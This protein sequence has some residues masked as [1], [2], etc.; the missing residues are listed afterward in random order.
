MGTLFPELDLADRPRSRGTRA[1]CASSLLDVAADRDSFSLRWRERLAKLYEPSDV[2]FASCNDSTPLYIAL[3]CQLV[4]PPLPLLSS[5]LC[6]STYRADNAILSSLRYYT[7]RF[8][9]QL[10]IQ[11]HISN[12][13]RFLVFIRLVCL[14]HCRITRITSR[15]S[16]SPLLEAHPLPRASEVA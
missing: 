11:Y 12:P 10:E 9:C 1:V 14:S 13:A 5:F 2:V 4:S 6:L 8:A 7:A 3:S 15:S 16:G